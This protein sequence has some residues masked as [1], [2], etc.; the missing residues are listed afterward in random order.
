[1]HRRT[2]LTGSA[3][4][5]AAG[6]LIP[7][8]ARPAAAAAPSA[9]PSAGSSSGPVVRTTAGRIRGARESGVAV[10]RG[11][12]YARP[13]VGRSR[14]APPA[15][16]LPWTGVREAAE[17]SRPF[18]SPGARDGSED[19]LYANVWTP[20]TAGRSPVL[21][22]VHGGAWLYNT[23]NNPTYDGTAPALR[24]DLVV[25]TFNYRLGC[26]GFGLHEEFGDGGD[27]D[28]GANWGL[29]DQ[30]ALLE[31]VHDNARAFGGDPDNITLCGTSAG[32]SSVWQLALRESTRKLIR[33]IVPVSAAHLWTPLGALT[34]E[35]ARTSYAGVAGQLET[36]VPGLR[37]RP[38]LE[39]MDAWEGRFAGDPGSRAVASGRYFRGPVVDGR[40]MTGYDHALPTPGLPTMVVNTRTEG[41][42]YT[43]MTAPAP[44]TEAE[45]RRMTREYLLLG[46][47]DVPGPLLDG[48][49]DA[50]RAAARAEGL[51]QDPLSLYTEIYG[52]GLFRYQILR[53][54]ERRAQESRAPQYHMDFAHP[55]L[56]PGHG[57]PH[58]A[59]SPF[60]FGTQGIPQN[61]PL[62]GDGPLERRVSATFIDLVA[63]FAHTGVPRSAHAP[64]WPVFSSRA[65]RSLVLGGEHVARIAPT[66][67]LRQL[68][69]WDRA[70]W[71]PRP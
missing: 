9:R 32:G 46:A 15:P 62:Y 17:F 21:V 70:G 65:P 44:E 68:E 50:Y 71:V 35:D 27:G 43:D 13:P 40:W 36:T 11:V 45:L 53:L 47:E 8:G 51:P 54:A 5:A 60:L 58:E 12:P 10:F 28:A 4:L 16:P 39:V 7:A 34:P 14:F 64:R 57:T 1:M 56:P 23:G 3:A 55:V 59:T 42:F 20:D 33:R 69:F 30:A 67:K 31:W 61:A 37:R 6:A 18:L 52:D 38:A 29:Q 22:Y 48:V 66:P 49:L 19:A 63:S 2:L 41:S 26:F 25:V 24:G